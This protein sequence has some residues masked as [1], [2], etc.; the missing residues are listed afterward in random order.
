MDADTAVAA[1]PWG[2]RVAMTLRGLTPGTSCRLVVHARDGRT[3]SV[4]SWRVSYKD[5]LRVEGMT[6]FGFDELDELEVVD[7][8]NQ[9]LVVVPVRTKERRPR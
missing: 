2:S 7:G 8:S 5:A 4:G 1:W 9:R 3:E 6:A